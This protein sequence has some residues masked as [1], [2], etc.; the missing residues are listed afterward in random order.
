MH[1]ALS[2]VKLTTIGYKINGKKEKKYREQVFE[3]GFKIGNVGNACCILFK[4]CSI[5]VNKLFSCIA[6]AKNK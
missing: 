5:N 3:K 1:S 4:R 2:G 6:V